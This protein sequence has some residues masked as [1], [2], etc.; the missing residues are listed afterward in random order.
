ME[1][2]ILITFPWG[3]QRVEGT[4]KKDGSNVKTGYWSH[5]ICFIHLFKYRA[6]RPLT[7]LKFDMVV[8][9]DYNLYLITP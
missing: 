8:K 2:Y 5:L 6:A 4:R 9:D 1:P 7:L 3:V